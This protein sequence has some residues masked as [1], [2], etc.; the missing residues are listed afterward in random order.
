M[1]NIILFFLCLNLS[2]A[3]SF[4]PGIPLPGL[5]KSLGQKT[6][7]GSTSV[8]IASDQTSI[9]FSSGGSDAYGLFR[10]TYTGTPVTT[11]AYLQVIA[12]TTSVINAVEIFDSS[13]Q[14]LALAFGGAGSEVNQIIIYP[15]GNGRVPL[16]IPSG[17]RV[18]VIALSATASSGEL[19][20]NFYE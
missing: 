5:P 4:S 14:T 3:Q 18:S 10:N 16:R 13:G 9:P 19:D 6:M 11:G 2:H 8:T 12:S 1:K 7:T 17:T 20:I 15:G